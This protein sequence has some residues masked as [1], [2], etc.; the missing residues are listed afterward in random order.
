[1]VCSKSQDFSRLDG[2]QTHLTG[3]RHAKKLASTIESKAAQQSI[4]L[5]LR[6]VDAK[7]KS[8]NEKVA[9]VSAEERAFR[10]MAMDCCLSAGIAIE[11][12]GAIAHLIRPAANDYSIPGASVLREDVLKAALTVEDEKVQVLLKELECA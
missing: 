2:I 6:T 10:V 11:Q 1:M 9:K 12:M 4:A 5:V 8:E 3:K 7:K